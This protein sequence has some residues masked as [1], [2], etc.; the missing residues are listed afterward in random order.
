MLVCKKIL[1]K[2][3]MQLSCVSIKNVSIKITAENRMKRCG[4]RASVTR[5]VLIDILNTAKQP[6]SVPEIITHMKEKDIVVNKSTV[7]REIEKLL[8]H[9]IIKEIYLETH[10]IRYE[11]ANKDH[12]HHIMCV[13]CKRVDDVPIEKDV[14]HHEKTI[15]KKLQYTIVNHSLE[16]F[17]VCKSCQ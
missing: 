15:E 10:K 7:Y 12:H 4:H 6:L 14:E 3:Q 16:F 8:N 5:D 2:L 11:I 1:N 13:S 9:D 17:G